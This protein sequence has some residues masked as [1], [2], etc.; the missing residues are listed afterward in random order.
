MPRKHSAYDPA[1]DALDAAAKQLEDQAA[2]LRGHAHARRNQDAGEK[3]LLA[4]LDT[5]RE[6][7]GRAGLP[8]AARA[9]QASPKAL[10]P[11]VRQIVQDDAQAKRQQRNRAILG[12]ARKGW[13]DG[14]IGEKFGLARGTVNRIVQKGFKQWPANLPESDL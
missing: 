6:A 7:Y 10:A 14:D 12:H 5:I 2:T 1:A 3:R 8:G 4:R 11:I 9:V 13:S